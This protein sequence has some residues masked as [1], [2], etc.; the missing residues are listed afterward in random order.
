MT[1]ADNVRR[2]R[3]RIAEAALKRAGSRK[4]SS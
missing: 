3:E 2:I 4:K 1:V